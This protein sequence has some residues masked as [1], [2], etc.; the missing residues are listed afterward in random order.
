MAIEL[1]RYVKRYTTL[2][3]LIDT[4]ENERIVLLDPS[5][6]DDK[7]D[8]YFM[9][10]YR[11]KC[12]A[13]SVSALCFTKAAETYHHW[14]IFTQ[15]M[16]GVCIEF[17]KAKLEQDLSLSAFAEH[18][19]I[20]YCKI[21]DL[22]SDHFKSVNDLPYLK[23]IGFRDEGEWRIV[24]KSHDEVRPT[25]PIPISLS[26]ISRIIINPWMPPSLVK[27]IRKTLKKIPKC[28]NIRIVHSRLINNEE[29]KNFGSS[30]AKRIF[31]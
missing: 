1:N 3:S 30:I 10:L 20:N 17:E 18:R 23:R 26:S 28:N 19:E 5:S 27:N 7:N 6:W 4:L 11:E 25:M 2:S 31:L 29:W 16:E 21:K 12:G 9:E 8:V 15:G 13:N 22:Q 24:A 14:K